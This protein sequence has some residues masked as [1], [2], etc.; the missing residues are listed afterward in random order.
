MRSINRV[1]VADI[2]AG[3][4][5]VI[6]RVGR[7]ACRH[8]CIIPER[9]RMLIP[10]NTFTGHIVK[11]FDRRGCEARLCRVVVYHAGITTIPPKCSL[12]LRNLIICTRADTDHAGCH[13]RHS[14]DACSDLLDLFH[15]D[16][17]FSVKFVSESSRSP[18]RIV[19]RLELH[20]I[21]SL[22]PLR[23]STAPIASSTRRM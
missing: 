17:P 16:F 12:A 8:R 10:V 4:P 20:D 9:C 3:S 21:R 22:I 23:T 2:S 5:A 11:Q 13:C 6:S 7:E 18:G 19:I 14:H 15:D 1:A